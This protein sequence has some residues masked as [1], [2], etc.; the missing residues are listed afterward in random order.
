MGCIGLGASA[1]TGLW[2]FASHTRVI[3]VMGITVRLLA[4]MAPTGQGVLDP[5]AAQSF[6]GHID[7]T[8]EATASQR[9]SRYG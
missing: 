4:P 2:E 9:D 7:P 1:P 8:T 3:T 6:A 5:M